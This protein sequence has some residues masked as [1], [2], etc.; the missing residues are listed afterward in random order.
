MKRF[1]IAVTALLWLSTMSAKQWTLD[2]C[3]EYAIN[4]NVQVLKSRA[5]ITG[6]EIEETAAKDA[7]LPNIS[8]GVNQSWSFGRG[9]TS[10]NI[11]ANRNTSQTG[12][13]VGAELPLFQGL[14]AKRRLDQSRTDL[15]AMVLNLDKVRDD[16]TLNIISAY[17]QVL[18][19]RELTSVAKLQRD[20][21]ATEVTRRRELLEAGRIPELDLIEAQSQLAQDELTVVT[22][23]NDAA[24]ALLDLKLLL[25][26]TAE[27][28]FDITELNDNE[29]LIPNP[30]TVYANAL[31]R[32]SSILL[33]RANIESARAAIKVAQTG[34]IPTLSFSTSVGSQ[35]YTVS[36]LSN[37]NF[38]KQMRDNFN[39]YVGFS[40][41]IPIF[42][43][44]ST[45]N[46]IR[47]AHNRLTTA[48]LD[49]EDTSN[50]LYK[51][52]NQA[53]YQAVAADKKVVAGAVAVEATRAAFDAMS[54]KYDYGRAT[55]TEFDQAKTNYIRATS[56][57]LQARYEQLLRSRILAFYNR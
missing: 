10:E 34:Y 2:D 49:L 39:T 17:L 36:G 45:R 8:A 14:A 22:T 20:L 35:Y 11:Y 52:I 21:S 50:N 5:E 56:E 51:A 48:L 28:D 47:R 38:G 16:L 1:I 44:F 57:H 25:N 26:L 6:G 15:R 12:W 54:A 18:Y 33:A 3:I 19:T 41:R 4:T 27:S 42:D 9:L 46:N 55:A 13:Q 29:I 31:E 40:L 24:L 32:N 23:E 43:A 53:Y 37:E 30:D 7:F